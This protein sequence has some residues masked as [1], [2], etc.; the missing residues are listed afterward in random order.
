MKRYVTVAGIFGASN[1]TNPKQASGAL[2]VEWGNRSL[3]NTAIQNAFRGKVNLIRKPLQNQFMKANQ[4][5]P[6]RETAGI[7]IAS[8]PNISK[9]LDLR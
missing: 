3:S 2:T 6:G 1:W 9:R 4:F 5:Y 8:I 7:W